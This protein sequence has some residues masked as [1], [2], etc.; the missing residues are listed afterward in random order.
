MIMILKIIILTVMIKIIVMTKT[1][2]TKTFANEKTILDENK[3]N[4]YTK[5]GRGGKSRWKTFAVCQAWELTY[6]LKEFLI[7]CHEFSN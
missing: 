6:F 5:E 7:A 1:V 4:K 3:T 2:V